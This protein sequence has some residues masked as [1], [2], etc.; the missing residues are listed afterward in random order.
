MDPDLDVG[1]VHELIQ[2]TGVVEMH[3][4]EDDLL[5]I[6][7]PVSGCFDGG[8]QLMS[9]LVLD[10]VE[11]VVDL[12]TPD[13]RIVGPRTGLPEDQAFVGMGDEDAVHGEFAAFVGE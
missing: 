12:W 10:A 6:F 7:N 9:R 2:S 3:V 1:P 13:L 11:D 5:D 4:S 8:F